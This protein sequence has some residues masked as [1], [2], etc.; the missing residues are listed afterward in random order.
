[1]EHILLVRLF[2]IRLR[3]KLLKLLKLVS[4][5]QLRHLFILMDKQLEVGLNLEYSFRFHHCGIQMHR[6]LELM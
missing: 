4:S 2:R 6:K 3:K 5:F 1:M